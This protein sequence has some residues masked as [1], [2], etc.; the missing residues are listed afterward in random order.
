MFNPSAVMIVAIVGIVAI[1][2]L[3]FRGKLR[4]SWRG[5]QISTERSTDEDS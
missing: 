2:A 5:W 1:V 4:I 3:V